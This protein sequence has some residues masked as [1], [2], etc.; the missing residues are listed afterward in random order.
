MKQQ[1]DRRYLEFIHLFN[2]QKYWHAHEALEH[3]WLENRECSDRTFYKALIQ[4]AAVLYHVEKGNFTGA[5][6]LFESAGRYLSEYPKDHLGISAGKLIEQVRIFTAGRQKEGS[7]TEAVR[8]I[9]Y[10]KH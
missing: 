1:Y 9:I 7:R 6:A 3:L 4:L 2:T 8:P 10:Y 5:W